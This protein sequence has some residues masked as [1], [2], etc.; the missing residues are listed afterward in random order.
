MTGARRRLCAA[1]AAAATL[2]AAPLGWGV[3]T[4]LVPA[5]RADARTAATPAMAMR[6]RLAPTATPGVAPRKPGPPPPAAAAPQPALGVSVLLRPL[7]AALV[8]QDRAQA[9][10]PALSW[11]DC[12]AQVAAAGAMRMAR[13]GFLSHAGG[14]IQDSACAP[15]AARTGENV[16]VWGGGVNDQAMNGLFMA[17][18]DH[19]SNILGRYRSIG[20][21][22]AVA[23]DGR[24]YVA[25]EFA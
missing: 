21:A 5:S 16:G 11:S 2:A 18:P 23:P 1:A 10:L 22:W 15:A 4:R 13:Q 9:G 12:L 17:S 3:A 7:Q 25:V 19:R 20:V 6:G 8:N 14:T 24:A